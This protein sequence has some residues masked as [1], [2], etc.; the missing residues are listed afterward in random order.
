MTDTTT[1]RARSSVD[2]LTQLREPVTQELMA[3]LV[4]HQQLGPLLRPVLASTRPLLDRRIDGWLAQP[5]E[6][7]DAVLGDLAAL[8]MVL[9]SDDAPPPDMAGALDRLLGPGGGRCVS[10]G[11]QGHIAAPCPACGSPVAHDPEL[12][13]L[14]RAEDEHHAAALAEHRADELDRLARL[15]D[16]QPP[17]PDQVAP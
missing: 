12:A 10:C 4:G 5:P 3:M 7:V 15:E 11:T 9:R 13:Q 1:P 14:A 6:R 2:K 16:E 8:L 17:P